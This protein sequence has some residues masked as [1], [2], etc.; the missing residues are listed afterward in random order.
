MREATTNLEARVQELSNRL[1][2]AEQ[3]LEEARRRLKEL[4]YVVYKILYEMGGRDLLAKQKASQG[5]H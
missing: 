3:Q 2:E 1:E 4:N 5:T